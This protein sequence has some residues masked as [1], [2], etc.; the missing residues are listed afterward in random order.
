MADAKPK[1]VTNLS[2][3][4]LTLPTGEAIPAGETRNVKDFS[5][6]EDNDVVKAWIDGKMLEVKD[7]KA[8]APKQ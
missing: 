2:D 4:A 7:A 1:S 8:P 3:R 5:K 6:S